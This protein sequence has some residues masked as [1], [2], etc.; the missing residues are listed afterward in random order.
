MAFKDW[1]CTH[2]MSSM[3]KAFAKMGW[4]AAMHEVFKVLD[5]LPNGNEINKAILQEKL[6]QLAKGD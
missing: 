3:E 2:Y 5:A 6:I 1:S 4:D